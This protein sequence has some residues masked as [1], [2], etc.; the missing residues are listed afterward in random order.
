MF[1]FLFLGGSWVSVWA[2]KECLKGHLS[3]LW[4][5]SSQWINML[6]DFT[7]CIVVHF[8]HQEIKLNLKF[9]IKIIQAQ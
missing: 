9:L 7:L 5:E 4:N 6:E 1:S 8:M 3:A 2:F